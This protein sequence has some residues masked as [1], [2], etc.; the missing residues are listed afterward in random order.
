MNFL[1]DRNVRIPR[2]VENDIKKVFEELDVY[3]RKSIDETLKQQQSS[4]CDADLRIFEDFP[5]VGVGKLNRKIS[6]KE[7]Q[8]IHYSP[9][10]FLDYLIKELHKGIE[11]R[12]LQWA[13]QGN[14]CKVECV[15]KLVE[16]QMMINKRV[17]VH[18]SACNQQWA[19]PTASK[20]KN[21]QSESDNDDDDDNDAGYTTSVLLG[22]QPEAMHYLKQEIAA[23]GKKVMPCKFPGCKGA[24]LMKVIN[25]KMMAK[26]SKHSQACLKKSKKMSI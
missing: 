4:D 3:N 17:Q 9:T 26:E 19:R 2:E 20:A 5:Q 25:G 14:D 22:G 6:K 11:N 7:L 16:G 15:T 24:M 1:Y 10:I 13:C 23:T 12:R 21:R 18:S 8:I